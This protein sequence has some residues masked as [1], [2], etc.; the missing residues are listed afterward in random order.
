MLSSLARTIDRLSELSGRLLTL[1]MPVMVLVI[2]IE[3]VARYLFS[4][5]TIWVYD[6][7]L[8]IYA[9][10]GMLGGAFA[11]KRDS[12]IRVDIFYSR[13]SDK[14]RAIL[15]IV[16]APIIAFFMVL[17]VWQVGLIAIDAL[18]TGSRRPT[19][20]APPLIL[21]LAP[22]VVGAAAILVQLLS[23]MIKAVTI[24]ADGAAEQ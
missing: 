20:W 1:L 21:F 3:V 15:D 17:V 2:A 16:G 19:E 23:N 24:L 7:A 13:F 8:M 12:H 14:G 4:A 6:S 22:I 5:P 10:V 11:M 18:E 9:W